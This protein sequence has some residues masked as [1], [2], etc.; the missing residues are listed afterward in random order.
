MY[1]YRNKS[2]QNKGYLEFTDP[3]ARTRHTSSKKSERLLT[4]IALTI[5]ISLSLMNLIA[6]KA[7]AKLVISLTVKA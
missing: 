3:P 4:I 6:R 7:I 1:N 2:S 5:K